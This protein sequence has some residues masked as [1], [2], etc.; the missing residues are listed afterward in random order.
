MKV[1]LKVVVDE[2]ER[3]NALVVVEVVL[4]KL[5]GNLNITGNCDK[6][7]LNDRTVCTRG[8]GEAQTSFADWNGVVARER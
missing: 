2:L 1:V 4:T 7:W 5:A 3:G 6:G 8:E